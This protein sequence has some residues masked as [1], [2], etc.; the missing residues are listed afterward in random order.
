MSIQIHKIKNR[1]QITFQKK[2]INFIDYILANGTQIVF[3]LPPYHPDAY[4]EL[5][6]KG[7]LKFLV[8]VEDMLRSL[9]QSRKIL[10]VGSYDPSSLNLS[11]KDFIDHVHSRDYVVEKIFKEYREVTRK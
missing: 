7:E 5:K 8:E 9:A 6:R 1:G 4:Q 3:F 10:L 2:F 11:S